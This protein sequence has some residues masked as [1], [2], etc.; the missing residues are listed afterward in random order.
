[1]LSTL[2]QTPSAAAEAV[3]AVYRPVCVLSLHDD[4]PSPDELQ[5]SSCERAVAI[6]EP[7]WSLGTI[8]STY[9]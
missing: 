2:S 1:M 4:V 8:S 3:T 6:L 7:W 9:S 5:S